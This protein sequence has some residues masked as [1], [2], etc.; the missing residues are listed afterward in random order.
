MQEIGGHTLS[1][2][3]EQ[4]ERKHIDTAI[5]LTSYNYALEKAQ[6]E[7]LPEVSKNYISDSIEQ[8]LSHSIGSIAYENSEIIGYLAFVAKSGSSLAS[9]PLYGYG[10]KHTKRG[11]IISRLFQDTASI[12][13]ENN[14]QNLHVDVFAH[15]SEVLWTYIMSAFA[16]GVTDLVRITSVPVGA[17]LNDYTFKEICKE[18]LV[19]HY[20]LDIIEF[21]RD[22]INH[23]RVSP[24]FYPC[25]EFLPIENRFNDFLTDSIRV[26]AAFE[27]DRLIGMVCS[28]PPDR[29]VSSGDT[30]AIHL[31][32]LFVAPDY[33]KHGV[34]VALL[35]FANN[36]LRKAGIKR[37]YV[38][39]G[40]INPT[41]R[42]FWDRHFINYSYS[43]T[44]QID[45]SMLGSIRSV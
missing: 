22:L 28:E 4:L 43:M 31:S 27:C 11:E 32:D 20:R 14:Y 8:L 19:I 39:H 16:M 12:L 5:K 36:E 45:S 42:G 15:D 1:I 38:T 13:C 21:Y 10:I 2:R 29:W 30:Q 23:L 26:F 34:A 6:N 37:I 40:T 17:L 24:V 7:A 25:N 33:R 9:S 41:A 35:Q 18:D 3:V 44:R